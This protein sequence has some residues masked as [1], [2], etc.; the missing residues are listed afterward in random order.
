MPVGVALRATSDTTAA[1]KRTLA[2]PAEQP[3]MGCTQWRRV[4]AAVL[5]DVTLLL[6]LAPNVSRPMATAAWPLA[7]VG[8]LGKEPST[9]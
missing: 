1:R 5:N 7:G 9:L 8:P 3:V 2:T 6:R 4:G